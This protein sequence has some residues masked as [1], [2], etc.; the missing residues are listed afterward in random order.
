MRVYGI[1][2]KRALSTEGVAGLRTGCGASFTDLVKRLEL[3]KRINRR[4]KTLGIPNV[5]IGRGG[6]HDKLKLNG[7]TIPIPRHS[8]IAIGTCESIMKS[9][10]S[11]LGIDWWRND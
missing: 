9:L 10:E 7:L 1:I 2:H 3:L 4:C 8:E 6:S 11:Q 5:K